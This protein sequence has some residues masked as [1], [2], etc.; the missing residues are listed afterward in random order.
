M[1][2]D[3]EA[4]KNCLES[5][6]QTDLGCFKSLESYLAAYS[7]SFKSFHAFLAASQMKYEYRDIL[8][9]LQVAPR[10]QDLS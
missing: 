1:E 4:I 10:L 3:V 7:H 5:E 9:L 8:Q 6:C 2:R